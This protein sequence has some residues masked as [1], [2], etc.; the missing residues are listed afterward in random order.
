VHF[1]QRR[2]VRARILG[3]VQVGELAADHQVGHLVAREVA[4]LAPR[5]ERPSRIT[6]TSSVMRSISSSFVR[7]VDHGHAVRLELAMRP[8]RRSVSEA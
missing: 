1:Q 3:W 2:R 4:G 8:K 7:D 6:T 5:H